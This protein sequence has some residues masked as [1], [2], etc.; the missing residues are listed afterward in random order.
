MRTA[1]RT[2]IT[3]ILFRWFLGEE[4]ILLALDRCRLFMRGGCSIGSALVFNPLPACGEDI[5]PYGLY[6][7]PELGST[8]GP[9]NFCMAA[10]ISWATSQRATSWSGCLLIG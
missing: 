5:P 7:K 9:L 1:R 4:K 8:S 3:T 2:S 6:P 10:S